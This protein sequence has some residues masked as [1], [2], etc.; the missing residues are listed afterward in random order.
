MQAAQFYPAWETLPHEDKL[1]P[2]ATITDRLKVLSGMTGGALGKRALPTT[3]GRDGAPRRPQPMIVT[4]V[5]ALMQRTFSP[6]QF[7]ALRFTI[8]LGQKLD[9]QDFSDRLVELGYHPE[10]QVNE[11][12]DI[13]VRGKNGVEKVIELKLTGDKLGMLK[14]SADHV[15]ENVKRLNL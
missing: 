12:G 14:K 10:F 4:S 2:A 13:A 7:T 11:R 3:P 1:P 8:T 5:Q 9:L 15:L 6:N